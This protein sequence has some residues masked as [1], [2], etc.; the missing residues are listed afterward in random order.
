MLQYLLPSHLYPERTY[1]LPSPTSTCIRRCTHTRTYMY[2]VVCVIQEGHRHG[3][4]PAPS[5]LILLSIYQHIHRCRPS[6]CGAPTSTQLHTQYNQPLNHD[7]TDSPSPSSTPTMEA[8]TIPA[9]K[10]TPSVFNHTHA[11]RPPPHRARDHCPTNTFLSHL[12][13]AY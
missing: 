2:A 5:L 11:P 7:Q 9:H 8:Y 13:V 10:L 4:R 1:V 12:S 3:V 6:S